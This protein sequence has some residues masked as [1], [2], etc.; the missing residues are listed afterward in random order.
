MAA[1]CKTLYW[2][3]YQ[4]HVLRCPRQLLKGCYPT[5]LIRKQKHRELYFYVILI[6]SLSLDHS[7]AEMSISGL[8]IWASGLDYFLLL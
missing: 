6:G 8:Q 5:L 7:G 3:W 4:H 1:A 2:A